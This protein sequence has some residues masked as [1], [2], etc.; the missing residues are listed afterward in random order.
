MVELFVRLGACVAFLVLGAFKCAPLEVAW[1][2]A[3]SLGAASVLG[4]RL[5]QRGMVNA[6]TAGFRAAFE[7]LVIAFF[8]AGSGWVSQLGFLVL[9]PCVYAGVQ[10]GSP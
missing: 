6:G 10:F 9:I 4:W 3:A 7:A 1:Q 8:L 5:E 2:A